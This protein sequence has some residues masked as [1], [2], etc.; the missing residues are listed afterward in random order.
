[1]AGLITSLCF[2]LGFVKILG[3]CVY[4]Y[5]LMCVSVC[6][7]TCACVCFDTFT[8]HIHLLKIFFSVL[9]FMIFVSSIA[10]FKHCCL[11]LKH[12]I[13]Y[14]SCPVWDGAGD[15]ETEHRVFCILDVHCTT[16]MASAL[17]FHI[18]YTSMASVFMCHI[19]SQWS[20]PFPCFRLQ[21]WWPS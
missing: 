16:E 3:D 4:V 15:R 5:V 7:P 8:R 12:S 19:H 6:S 2:F 9:N 14:Q 21:P 18:S 11:A 10:T 13:C 17:S 20:F 1:M